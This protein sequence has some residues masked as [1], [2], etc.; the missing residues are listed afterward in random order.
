VTYGWPPH[1]QK[2][3]IFVS[4][5][6]RGDRAYYEAF[7]RVFCDSYDILQD[8]SVDREIDSDNVEYVLRRIREDYITGTSC[9]IVLCGAETSKRKFVDWEIKATLDKEHGLIGVNLPSNFANLDGT[10]PT[11]DRFFDNYKS[12]YAGWTQWNDIITNVTKFAYLVQEARSKDR[13]RIVNSRELR[14]RNG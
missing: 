3:K 8:R 14:T 13:S 12:G 4:Y 10:V 6:H 5:H 9:T 2:P 7:A 11:P 1:F